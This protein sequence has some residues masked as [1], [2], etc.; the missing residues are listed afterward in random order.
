MPHLFLYLPMMHFVFFSFFFLLSSYFAQMM[1][2]L[3]VFMSMLTTVAFGIRVDFNTNTG[4]CCQPPPTTPP[5]PPPRQPYREP[6]PVW[7]DQSNDIPNPD[8]YR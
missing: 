5:P 4:P 1:I 3:L 6:A 2:N 7:E 8:P